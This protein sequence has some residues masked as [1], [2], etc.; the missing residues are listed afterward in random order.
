MTLTVEQMARLDRLLDQV[1]D[2]DP[3]ERQRWLEQLPEAEHD[4]LPFL[5]EAMSE[6]GA[7]LLESLPEFEL[8]EAGAGLKPGACIGAY[9]LLRPLGTG[10]MAQVW[11]AR[12]AD[13]SIKR[14]VA[15]KIPSVLHVRGDLAA[16][17]EREKDILAALEHPHIARLYDAGVSQDGMPFLAIEHVNG[18]P[19][20]AWC[21]LLRMPIKERIILFLQVLEAVE[22]AH[23]KGVLHRDF[24]PSN[25]LVTQ[26]GQIRLLDFGIAKLLRQQDAQITRVYGRALTPNYASPEQLKDEDLS[27]ASDI[28]SLGV[29][30][31]EL[32]A[33]V[34][35]YQLESGSTTQQLPVPEKPSTKIDAKAAEVRA[36][37]PEK[38]VRSLKGDLDAIVMK[39][40][41][42]NVTQRYQSARDFAQ[43]LKAYLDGRPIKA[44]PATAMTRLV[45]LLR[46]E[47]TKALVG[48]LAVLL[49][50]LLAF[51]L[52]PISRRTEA[53]SVQARATPTLSIPI[54][55]KSIAVLPFNDM[56]EHHD[57]EYFSDG[58]SEELIDQLARSPDLKVIARTSSFYFKGKQVPV[59]EIAKTLGVAHLLVG[60]V[61]KDAQH[62]RITAQLVRASDGAQLWSQTY[63]RNASAIFNVQDEIASTVAHA[64]SAKLHAR[65]LS[66]SEKMTSSDAYDLFLQGDYFHH[67]DNPG[68]MQK[69]IEYYK[70][71]IEVD[72][73]YALAWAELGIVYT[74][75]ASEHER[76]VEEVGMQARG[77][78]DR[79]L[80]IDPGLAR[81]HDALGFFHQILTWDWSAARSEYQRA[82]SLDPVGRVVRSAQLSLA[83]LDMIQDGK[84]EELVRFDLEWLARDPLN[85]PGI[86]LDL[87]LN[88]WITGHWNDSAAS[89]EK[90]LEMNPHV[91][92]GHAWYAQTLLFLG[93]PVD[94]LA[95]AEKESDKRS[96]LGVL[97]AI[98]WNLGQKGQSDIALAQ[99]EHEFADIA[100]T[101]IAEMYAYRGEQNKAFAWLER[102][103]KAHD[104]QLMYLKVDPYL[105][106]LRNDPRYHRLLKRMKL[107]E[108]EA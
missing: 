1:I 102:G 46:R 64:L 60:S 67:R 86:L 65:D 39:A 44:L 73:N 79:A 14:E 76:S 93:K 32:I 16:R 74:V 51:E 22:Y 9:Q 78:I 42:P 36:A 21:D 71:A 85:V 98:Y 37:P 4:L 33:G 100:P 105:R 106:L 80:K 84:V 103:Y 87:A 11:L 75:Q 95:Q 62:L 30:L 89:F 53:T 83:E 104:P 55:D 7:V 27:P 97:P 17:F 70:K 56:S 52:L 54:S 3:K 68:D 77:A 8:E 45:K 92:S 34:L 31:Y 41:A 12:R 58:L 35:P 107:H 94:A 47:P 40:I 88:Q 72:P 20:T 96:R 5:Q 90:L 63:D 108:T 19:I 81:A 29:L 2:L 82:I 38:L 43:D 23:K 101:A 59:A 15:L 61:R 26:D 99:L 13:G 25:V 48:V 28:Y 66:A 69:A 49:L 6:D 24:K 10:G 50:G 91:V 18:Q 57:Q